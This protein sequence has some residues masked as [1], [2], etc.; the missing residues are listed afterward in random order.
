MKYFIN[1]SSSIFYDYYT[2]DHKLIAYIA[3]QIEGAYYTRL[4]ESELNLKFK[5]FNDANEYICSEL[6]KRG[7]ELLPKKLEILL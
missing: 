1:S 3:N 7:Y 5:S 2:I 4:M 6:L